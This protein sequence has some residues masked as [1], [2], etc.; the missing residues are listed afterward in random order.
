[1]LPG[2]TG[3]I[4]VT[5]DYEY[6]ALNRIT[7]A[8]YTDAEN[9]GAAATSFTY[10]YDAAGNVEE[11]VSVI[12]GQTVTTTYRYNAANELVSATRNN[13]VWV[14]EYDGNG[15]LLST[16]P[17]SGLASGSKKYS[18]NTAG[19]LTKVE[20]YAGSAWYTQAEM[21][22]TGLGDRLSMTGSTEDGQSISTTYA[23]SNGTVLLANASGKVTAYL[24]GNGAIGEQTDQWSYALIDGTGTPRQ[25][26]DASA[27]VTAIAS[28]TPW[29]DVLQSGGT[30]SFATG[31]MGGMLD[32]TT[33][34]IYV[35]NGQYF[36][37]ETGRFLTRGN[38]RNEAT[39]PYTPWKG[40]PTQALVSPML[41]LALLYT[42]RKNRNKFDTLLV[43]LVLLSAVGLS[44][45]AYT[46]AQAE[47]LPAGSGGGVGAPSM[48][49]GYASAAEA[50]TS[51]GVAVGNPGGAV[52]SP[53]ADNICGIPDWDQIT[54]FIG[55][56]FSRLFSVVGQSYAG[57][58]VNFRT[59]W[60][61]Y[62]NPDA[63][64]WQRI[65]AKLYMDAWIGAHYAIAAGVIL[66][67][68]AAW[69]AIVGGSN[70][71]LFNQQ[72]K[73]GVVSI[74]DDTTQ[75]ADDA[76]N[77]SEKS[78]H[79]AFDRHAA[80]LGL[81]TKW[82]EAGEIFKKLIVDTINGEATQQILG[83]FR[84]KDVI[85]FF[86]PNTNINVMTD[87]NG[88]FMSIWVLSIKQVEYLLTTGKIGGG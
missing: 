81:S 48:P 42:R 29:G 27:K 87:L 65:V 74:A 18:Y 25:M 33:G 14:Y 83:I 57:G 24:Y 47:A 85:N 5:I 2:G 22:Y 60:S 54:S 13:V 43:V 80:Q 53:T 78:L 8:I 10:S 67:G 12:A 44:L 4:N 55:D 31:M 68:V 34:L 6:D 21:S 9:I 11:Y 16:Q 17:E 72:C 84:G 66:L 36:D 51:S 64:Y 15:A 71:C 1:M 41:L 7:S 77:M 39:N 86:D 75:F 62:W 40:D 88:E 82:G 49:M 45:S 63:K 20:A 32:A 3:K 79:H 35:G 23:L 61:I 56:E 59:A 37:P 52:E 30:G 76:I 73:D 19:Y 58:W 70:L 46:P 28:Y 50:G 38:Q 69:E 26:V